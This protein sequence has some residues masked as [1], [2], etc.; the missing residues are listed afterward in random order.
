MSNIFKIINFTC[1]QIQIVKIESMPLSILILTFI[2]S[3]WFI[4]DSF[5]FNNFSNHIHGA[6]IIFYLQYCM[7]IK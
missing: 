3:F 6:L 5:Y 7:L 2:V 4:I 1:I